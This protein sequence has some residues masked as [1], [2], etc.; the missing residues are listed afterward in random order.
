MNKQLVLRRKNKNGKSTRVKKINMGKLA[1]KQN[2]RVVSRRFKAIRNAP[3]AIGTQLRTRTARVFRARDGSVTISHREPLGIQLGHTNFQATQ[4][5]VNPGLFAT[6]PWLSRMA[7]N[8]EAY[9]FE[10]LNIEYI[11]SVGANTGGSICIAPD[12]NSTDSI[13][14]NLQQMEQYQDA[15]RDVVWN[16]GECIIKP[17]GMGVLGPQRYM[18][19]GPIPNGQDGKTYD[20]CTINVGTSGIGI[21][22]SQIG[23]LWVNYTV[24]LLIPNS[25]ISDTL[26]ALTAY[27]VTIC[28]GMGGP[29]PGVTSTNLVGNTTTQVGNIIVGTG[30]ANNYI[31]VLRTGFQIGN[32]YILTLYVTG[33]TF[34]GPLVLA[35]VFGLSSLVQIGNN[36]GSNF[37]IILAQITTLNETAFGISITGLTAATIIY[38]QWCITPEQ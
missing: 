9:R 19:G 35:N 8:F 15:W 38:T 12:Y 4:F 2:S 14:F 11:T 27:G 28:D 20:V 6:F 24:T 1:R 32:K 5:S 18:R 7:Q 37:F 36:Q 33:T 16:N 34:T 25:Y 30:T 21:D 23:E 22:G 26:I 17:K 10:K 13:P 31:I 3:Q 29:A